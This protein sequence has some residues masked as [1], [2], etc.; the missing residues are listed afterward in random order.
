VVEFQ[1]I[2]G[3]RAEYRLTPDSKQRGRFWTAT[4]L[5]PMQET[6]VILHNIQAGY[7]STH[8]VRTARMYTS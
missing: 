8:R 7:A 4:S 1:R 6:A 2:H 3:D 5:A